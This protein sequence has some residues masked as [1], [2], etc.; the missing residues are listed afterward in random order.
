MKLRFRLNGL[1]ESNIFIMLMTLYLICSMF[2]GY[3]PELSSISSFVILSIILYILFTKRK[4]QLNNIHFILIMWVIYYFSSLI[5]GANT[6][7]AQAKMYI[8]TIISMSILFVLLTSSTFS[9]KFISYFIKLYYLFS[10]ILGIV[11]LF[12]FTYIGAGTRRVALLFGNYIDPNNQVALLAVGTAI[13]LNQLFFLKNNKRKILD[14]MALIINA[15]GIL[16]TGS[17]SGIIIIAA[18][19]L[20]SFFLLWRYSNKKTFFCKWIVIILLVIVGLIL[21]FRFL[22]T[23]I[24][25]RL[26]GIGD[27]KFTDGTDREIR[28]LTGLHI[29]EQ[30]PLFGNGWGT[31]ESHNTF[32]TIL[33]DIGV[34]GF[35]LLLAMILNIMKKLI[36]NKNTLGI[37]LLLTG[38]IPSFFIGAQNKRFFWN[39]LIIPVML[40]CVRKEKRNV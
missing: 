20:I 7:F 29:W 5:W 19:I 13:A 14:F 22:P 28:W 10:V 33:I 35:C 37:Y 15:I 38:L 23:E 24:I 21:I 11:S 36:K 3:S 8:N 34:I 25:D 16:L 26:F 9:E 18:Q 39:C 1:K 2:E 32:L 31:F 40:L 12:S 30:H 6:D 17:R 4:M 27:L